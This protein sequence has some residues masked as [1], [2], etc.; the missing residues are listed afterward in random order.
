MAAPTEVRLLQS[1]RFEAERRDF[2]L[3]SPR[4]R[5][6]AKHFYLLALEEAERCIITQAGPHHAA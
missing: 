4:E 3:R 6:I 2:G 5:E 1:L